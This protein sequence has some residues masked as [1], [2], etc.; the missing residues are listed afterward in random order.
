RDAA[1][2]DGNADRVDALTLLRADAEVIA[3]TVL[4]LLLR[5]R[6]RERK[7]EPA[8][9]R[10]LEA[11]LRPSV[12]QEEKLQP[13]LLAMLAQHAAVPEHLGPPARGGRD[14]L[15]PPEDGETTGEVRIGREPAADPQRES[16]LARSG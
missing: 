6:G 14:V 7:S 15:R 11:R 2:N 3:E 9:Q 13:R 4:R 10:L 8:L 1:A 16:H 12:L 5:H